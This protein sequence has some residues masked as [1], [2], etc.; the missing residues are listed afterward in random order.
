MAG[1][2]PGALCAHQGGGSALTL[3]AAGLGKIYGESAVAVRHAELK[4]EDG[5]FVSIV[6]RSGSG[7]STLLAMIG[8]LTRPTSGSVLLDEQDIWALPERG[9]ADLRC[10]TF[11]FVFQVPS[12]LPNLQAID[13]VAL[14]ALLGHTLDAA[15]AYARA[16]ELLDRTGLRRRA[17]AYP[18]ELSGGEQRR[19]AIARALINQPRFL[20]ADEPTGDL[21]EDTENDV[22]EMLERLRAETPFGLLLV[23][24]NLALAKLAD[25]CCVMERGVL[26]AIELPAPVVAPAALLRRFAPLPPANDVAPEED[27]HDALRLGRNLWAAAGRVM[28]G[29]LA[30]FAL[31]LAANEGLDRYQTYAMQER[32]DKL[33]V[34]EELAM[35][36]LQGNISSVVM[37]SDGRY[38]VEIY[39][40]NTGGADAPI[41]IMSPSVH[42]FVQVGLNWQEV[43]LAPQGDA[44]A[45]VLKVVGRQT[46]TYTLDARVDKFTQ[47]LPHYMHVRFTN[48]MLVS[49]ESVPEDDL[50]HREDSYYIYLRPEGIDDATIAKSVKFAGPPP[51]WIWM[52]P[53]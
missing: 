29:G 11:G 9:L 35:S 24:H 50:F 45:S 48:S 42:A 1:A 4:L 34:I 53:H 43:P 33:A 13:N 15:D 5:A 17:D 37:H 38:G 25:R 3:H 39:L 44:T 41:Y 19:V 51:T 49:P 12:L 27:A 36:T 28:A 40:E 47:L 52:P 21:D 23:T 16:R 10:R 31:I 26:D 46:Y 6:G 7:K 30:V 18:A 8:A 22:I 20:L 2:P 14:P 32:R